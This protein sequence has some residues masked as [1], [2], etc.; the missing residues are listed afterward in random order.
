MIEASSEFL[1]CRWSPTNGA[2]SRVS[3]DWSPPIP[4][5]TQKFTSKNGENLGRTASCGAKNHEKRTHDYRRK[6][7]CVK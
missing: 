1:G 5:R 4:T 6:S 7:F 2:P 3:P